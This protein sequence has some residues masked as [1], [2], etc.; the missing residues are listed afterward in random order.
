MSFQGLEQHLEKNIYSTAKGKLR[1]N[2]LW[3][4]LLLSLPELNNK[5]LNILDIGGGSGH[6]TRRLAGLGHRVTLCDISPSM[7]AEAREQNDQAGLSQKIELVQ[8]DIAKLH[9]VIKGKFDLVLIHV[10]LGWLDQPKEAFKRSLH[11]LE[12]GGALSL[13]YYNIDRLIIKNGIHANFRRIKTGSYVKTGKGR[14]LTPPNPLKHHE[15]LDWLEK[16]NLKVV[17]KAGIRIFFDMIRN[18]EEF[19]GRMEALEEVEKTYSR[20]EPYASI[21]QHI[22]LVCRK[23]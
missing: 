13:L 10:V 12:K 15:V 18:E 6:I 9:S 17:S 7:L 14:K 4:D 21:A 20:L 22:H 8:E 19:Q 2:V 3:H 23:S 11:F 5:S 16:E 1:L